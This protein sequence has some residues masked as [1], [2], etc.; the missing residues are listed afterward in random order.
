MK[1]IQVLLTLHSVGQGQKDDE[2]GSSCISVTNQKSIMLFES[3]NNARTI[4]VKLLYIRSRGLKKYN[5]KSF[6][7]II[8]EKR[9]S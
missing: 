3:Q 7:H 5:I 1:K 4:Q 6:D 2:Y 9:V 8:D